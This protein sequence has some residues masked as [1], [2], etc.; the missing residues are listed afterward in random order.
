MRKWHH[1]ILSLVLAAGLLA[2]SAPALASAAQPLTVKV[3]DKKVEY[4]AGSGA[5][6]VQQKTTLVPLRSTLKAM[7]IT[8]SSASGN[9][10]TAIVNGKSVTVKSK[11]TK[12]N[13]VVYVPIRTFGELTG[14][15]VS[16]NAKTR[17]IQL[18][19]A[20]AVPVTTEPI[21]TQ[22]VDSTTTAPTDSTATP[23]TPA[24][25][26]APTDSSPSPA[27]TT[28]TADT[29]GRGFMWEVQAN[30]NTV[31]LVGS[32]HIANDSFYPLRK[33]YE[34]AFSQADYL[35]VEVD[36]TK[37]TDEQFFEQIRQMG[38]YQDGSTLPNHIAADTYAKL[39]K[40]LQA[41]GIKSGDMDRF[42]PWVV[43]MFID[44]A[45]TA[46]SS[47]EAASGIDRY[48]LKQA[49]E[50]NVP[51]IELESGESQLSMLNNF[52]PE[53]QDALLYF[54]LRDLEENDNGKQ[55][56]AIDNMAETWK[57]GNEAELLKMT[58]SSADI[59]EYHKA[60]LVDRNIGMANKIDGYLKSG[61]NKQYFI[62][63]GAAHYLSDDGILHLLE[64]KGYTV[65][66]K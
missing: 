40:Y 66:R 7:G 56:E 28:E 35:G 44:S 26:T 48:F 21:T 16:W 5:P 13:G 33:E 55:D 51:V 15:T 11:L 42:K 24:A 54:A 19:S 58:T 38:T 25:S 18:T 50:R 49:A 2:T 47:Y 61:G 9:S 31:Y 32:M 30:G 1:K 52:S 45:A 39:G 57:T 41:N 34:E 62:V 53:L 4:R 65:V 6:T 20:P 37:T 27:A 46:N 14:Y 22:P 43:E 10:I 63:V 60:M 17:T 59:P 29:G 12:I 8:L 23:T 3:N 64:K 36:V